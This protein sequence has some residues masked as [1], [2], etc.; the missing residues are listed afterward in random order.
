MANAGRVGFTTSI[1]SE[2]ERLPSGFQLMQNYPNPFNPNTTIQ[3]QMPI[4]AHVEIHIYNALGE[5]ITTL[6]NGYL[7]DGLHSFKFVA[8]NFPSGIYFYKIEG[9]E[10]TAIR[11]ML[12]LK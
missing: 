7:P 4:G 2:A 12:L 8:G 5:Q 1:A 3:F 9:G 11:K 10:F 6:F